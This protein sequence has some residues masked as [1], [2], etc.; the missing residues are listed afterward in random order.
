MFLIKTVEIN[1]FVGG[2]DGFVK[3]I[4]RLNKCPENHSFDVKTIFLILGL[5]IDFRM[6]FILIKKNAMSVNKVL[7]VISLLGVVGGD[8]VF[9]LRYLIS[10]LL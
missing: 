6:I 10:R 4:K 5:E 7:R 8:Q 2:W 9:V 3:K 1:I